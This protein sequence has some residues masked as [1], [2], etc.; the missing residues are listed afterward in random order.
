MPINSKVGRCYD[1][2]KDSKGKSSAAAIC[3]SSTKESLKTGKMMKP[4]VIITITP[5]KKVR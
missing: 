3:Q 1:K 5:K 4:M 2:M